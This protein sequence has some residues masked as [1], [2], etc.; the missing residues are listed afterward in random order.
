MASSVLG[1]RP[2]RPYLLQTVNVPKPEMLTIHLCLK[3][4]LDELLNALEHCSSFY[5]RD[6]RLLMDLG[7]NSTLVHGRVRNLR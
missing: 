6:T 5:H 4:G 3:S 2:E 7:G 1:F